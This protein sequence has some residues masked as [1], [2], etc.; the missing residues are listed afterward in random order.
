MS[1]KNKKQTTKTNE[2]KTEI[3]P[4]KEVVKDTTKQEKVL[5]EQV[6]RPSENSEKYPE[7]KELLT[8]KESLRYKVILSKNDHVKFRDDVSKHL[9]EGW[10]LAGGDC[11]ALNSNQYNVEVIYSQAVTR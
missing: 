6:Y 2:V 3:V 8:S 11:I 5:S 4:Q 10:T 1:S 9:Y 7:S